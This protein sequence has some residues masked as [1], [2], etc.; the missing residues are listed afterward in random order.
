MLSEEDLA[1]LY[2]DA[3]ETF[4]W[5]ARAALDTGAAFLPVEVKPG[6]D[7]SLHVNSVIRGGGSCSMP[8]L[9]AG[10]H[11]LR[12][13]YVL[14]AGLDTEKSYDLGQFFYSSAQVS[15]G[16]LDE[17][18]VELYDESIV[19]TQDG[20][21]TTYQVAAGT[22]VTSKVRGIILSAWPQ[23]RIAITESSKTLRS[24]MDWE[25]KATWLEIINDL[26]DS[27]NYFGLFVD[28]RSVFTAKPYV[29]PAKRGV[30]WEFV[31][32]ENCV[33][34]PEFMEDHDTFAVPN[35]VLALPR[36]DG[37]S[38]PL[39]P[40]V[41]TNENAAS[42]YSY[43]ARGRWIRLLLEDVEAADQA[44]LLGRAKR[45]LSEATS[46]GQ[47]LSIAHA[48]I[49]GLSLND[50]VWFS[51]KETRGYYVIAGQEL[52]METPLLVKSSLRRV[53]V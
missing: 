9:P 28:Q 27:I 7:L 51:D 14:D 23:A 10:D 49:P 22:V 48:F 5:E 20:P 31:D 21:N 24:T 46:V 44:T 6:A 39:D 34:L 35:K 36:S 11:L 2:S 1:L 4:I 16:L 29:D 8:P 37:E 18:R 13:R 12:A 45:S 30:A 41:V 33:H 50:V 43:Q 3:D 52:K 32:N 19:L 15:H 17:A 42:P 53:D 26:L 47:T 38:T 25:P 40:V